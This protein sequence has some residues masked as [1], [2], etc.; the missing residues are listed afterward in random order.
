MMLI[1]HYFLQEIFLKLFNNI[2]KYEEEKKQKQTL[3]Q[4]VGDAS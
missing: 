2:E 3:A 4:P 1:I